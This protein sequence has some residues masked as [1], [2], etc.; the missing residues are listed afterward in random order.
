MVHPLLPQVRR[1]LRVEH[2][3]PSGEERYKGV[4]AAW[5]VPAIYSIEETVV[6][7]AGA[8]DKDANGWR[9]CDARFGTAGFVTGTFGLT[10]ASVIT[11]L[12]ATGAPLPDGRAAVLARLPAHSPA[13]PVAQRIAERKARRPAGAA[14]AP[15]AAVVLPPSPPPP[16]P[17][18]TEVGEV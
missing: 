17:S 3:F 13:R 18:E 4:E 9:D 14:A 8:A 5:G 7:A 11:R 16:P 6:V 1:S 12:L 2:A 10:A 15:P